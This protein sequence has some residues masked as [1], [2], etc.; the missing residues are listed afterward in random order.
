MGECI[1]RAEFQAG[2][3]IVI[4]GKSAVFVWNRFVNKFLRKE[5]TKKGSEDVCRIMRRRRWRLFFLRVVMLLPPVVLV[6]TQG[7]IKSH[8]I[9]GG[10]VRRFVIL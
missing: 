5:T 1:R 4:V 6:V 8:E 9:S 2:R 3:I 7:L 10:I